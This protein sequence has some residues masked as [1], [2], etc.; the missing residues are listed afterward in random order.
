MTTADRPPRRLLT[1]EAIPVLPA[2]QVL[3]AG[4][5]GDTAKVDRLRAHDP[6]ALTLSLLK[7]GWAAY[8]EG[9]YDQVAALATDREMAGE[10]A[11]GD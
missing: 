4:L 1:D 11:I 6:E 7:L 2:C 10:S 8:E 5:D 3:L 9:I